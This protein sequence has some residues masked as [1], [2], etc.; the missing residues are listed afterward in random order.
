MKIPI[1][2]RQTPLPTKTSGQ[3]L[4]SSADP[5]KFGMA[6]GAYAQLG[7][8]VMNE[9]L[10]WFEKGVKQ[11]RATKVATADAEFS[12]HLTQAAHNSKYQNVQSKYWQNEAGETLGLHAQRTRVE[13]SLL[14]QAQ[15]QAS[16]ISDPVVR[17]RFLS[18]TTSS[19]ASAMPQIMTN[20]TTSWQQ[21]SEGEWDKT[22]KSEVF[23]IAQI[24]NDETRELKSPTTVWRMFGMLTI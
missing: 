20:L 1:Y 5:G 19:I 13:Q 12:T 17:R 9:G 7:V 24:E 8:D 3:Y 14:A 21:Y 4:G 15:A 2:R 23:R 10:Q 22:S 16:N 11:V 18:N 6:A